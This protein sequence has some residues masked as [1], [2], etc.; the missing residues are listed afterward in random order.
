MRPYNHYQTPCGE[1]EA[2]AS[3][4]DLHRLRVAAA[5]LLVSV[6][7]PGA[8][9]AQAVSGINGSVGYEGGWMESDGGHNVSATLSVPIVSNFGFQADGLYTRVSERDFYT[10]SGHFFWRKPETGLIGLA[11]GGLSQEAMRSFMGGVEGEYYLKY[12]TLG[13][14][15]GVGS[16]TYDNPAPFIDTDVT[17]FVGSA[18]AGA[19]PWENLLVGVAYSYLYDNN[20][21][22]GRLEYQTPLRGLSL[23]VDLARGDHGYDH[24]LFGARYYF[25]KKKSLKARHRE[26]DPLGMAQRI[27]Y[28]LGLYGAEFNRERGDYFARQGTGGGSTGSGDPYG[29]HY[30]NDGYGLVITTSPR[31]AP[32]ALPVASYPVSQPQ[33]IGDK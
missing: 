17:K 25:G 23:T 21:V 11:G 10:G 33:R 13:A 20:L 29:C 19:Y 26:D 5:I 12:F 14:Y 1:P 31:S 4:L 22:Q 15:A 9:W 3:P 16:I 30:Y 24:A 32:V 28:G 7:P 18:S 2:L 27:L 6:I 8:A